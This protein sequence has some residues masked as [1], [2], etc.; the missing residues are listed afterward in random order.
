MK[1]SC[2]SIL[3]LLVVTA[4]A[5]QSTED[6]PSSVF[7]DASGDVD[8]MSLVPYYKTW[9]LADTV[10]DADYVAVVRMNKVV[11]VKYLTPFG[12]SIIVPEDAKDAYDRFDAGVAATPEA[13]TYEV[14]VDRWIKGEGDKTIEI[15]GS[16]GITAKGRPIFNDGTFL[17]E[18]G[19]TYLLTIWKTE[20]GGL[21]YG[22]A[23]ASFDLTDGVKVLNH[24]DT[25]DL[26]HFE[27]M[28]VDEFESYVKQLATATNAK[29][30]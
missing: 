15:T 26:E 19:R 1:I 3:A 30:D 25:R 28:S 12:G 27:T 5:C 22:S 6:T 10:T 9:E 24:Y 16:G 18:P 2:I 23:R 21:V 4:F 29:A 13:T 11:E 17:L 14:T 7:W 8:G 20:A